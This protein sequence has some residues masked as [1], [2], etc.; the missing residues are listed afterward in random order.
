[1]EDVSSAVQLI[2]GEDTDKA[3]K[4]TLAIY[5]FS[6]PLDVLGLTPAPGKSIRADV[7]VLRGNG[8]QTLQ[9]AYWSNKATGLV[10]DLPSEAE[11]TPRLWGMWKFE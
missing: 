2:S 5:E 3:G 6:I 1:V 7:G 9:R 4:T 11:L 8:F 10:S